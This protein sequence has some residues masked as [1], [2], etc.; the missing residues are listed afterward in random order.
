M[1]DVDPKYNIKFKNVEVPMFTRS[2]VKMLDRFKS[3]MKSV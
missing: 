3:Q 1:K 2:N